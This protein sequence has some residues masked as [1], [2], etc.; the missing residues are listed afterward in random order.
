MEF[1]RFWR[2]IEKDPSKDEINALKEFL[3]KGLKVKASPD[4][5]KM[6]DPNNDNVITNT[7]VGATG[8]PPKN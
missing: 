3:K 5:A 7:N 8:S 4:F 1:Y 6:M 2:T